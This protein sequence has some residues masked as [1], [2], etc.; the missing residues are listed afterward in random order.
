M[1][2]V[3]ECY[4]KVS[5]TLISK[6]FEVHMEMIRVVLQN[7]KTKRYKTKKKKKY[8]WNGQQL[9]KIVNGHKEICSI[10]FKMS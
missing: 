4:S 9:K 3:S 7:S 5:V 1:S 8:R 2:R 6:Y 10:P